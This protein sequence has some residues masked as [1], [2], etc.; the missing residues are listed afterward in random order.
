MKNVYLIEA[1]ETCL[2]TKQYVVE[3]YTIEQARD[4]VL[5][6]QNGYLDE[7]DHWITDELG[8]NEILNV[9]H[10]RVVEEV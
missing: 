9:K 6:N 1:R 2:V 3:A 10:T 5:G 8:V 4:V 7:V